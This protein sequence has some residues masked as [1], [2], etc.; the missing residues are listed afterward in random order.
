M[1]QEGSEGELAT[2]LGMTNEEI[3]AGA[4]VFIPGQSVPGLAVSRTFGDATVEELGVTA[5]PEVS[6][7]CP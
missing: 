2:A 1:D 6:S 4:R 3:R 7:S 5:I